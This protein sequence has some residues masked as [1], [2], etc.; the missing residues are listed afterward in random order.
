MN[1][2]NID[3]YSIESKGSNTFRIEATTG[4]KI[5][6]NLF[7]QIKP[8]NDEMIKLLLKAKEIVASAKKE[9]IDLDFNVDIDNSKPVSY[10]DI[11]FN[12]NELSYVQKEVKTLEKK[13]NELKQNKT[14]SNLDK[15]RENIEE[16]KGKKLLVKQI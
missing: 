4:S 1:T 8:Y 5:T 3:I 11:I 7:E 12:K 2:Y 9:G 13:Y 15:Y 14:L 6:Q 10:K 16:T